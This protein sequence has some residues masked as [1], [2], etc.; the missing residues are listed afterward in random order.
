MKNAMTTH[1]RA[2]ER[3]LF[4]S[5]QQRKLLADIVD[6]LIP[7]TDGLPG[8]GAAGVAEHVEGIAGVAP[9][10]RAALIDGLKAI[11]TSALSIS[12]SGV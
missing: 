10:S 9:K 1:Y 4:L 12:L 11:E 7:M 6:Q 5:P 8:T 3:S 2:H